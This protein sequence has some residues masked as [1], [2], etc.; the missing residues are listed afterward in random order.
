MYQAGAETILNTIIDD[1]NGGF[2]ILKDY[3]HI[4]VSIKCPHMVTATAQRNEE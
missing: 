2:F 4:E 1:K 3:P